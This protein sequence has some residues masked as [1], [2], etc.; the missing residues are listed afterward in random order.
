MKHDAFRYTKDELRRID[1]S[2]KK[3]DQLSILFDISLMRKSMGR[4]EARVRGDDFTKFTL[5]ERNCMLMEFYNRYVSA[6]WRRE[7]DMHPPEKSAWIHESVARVIKEL[8]EEIRQQEEAGHVLSE[9]AKSYI[10]SE[11]TPEMEANAEAQRCLND[12]L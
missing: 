11:C 10:R 8:G 1:I 7:I 2:W 9:W 6:S 5:Y 12:Y 3:N 4:C